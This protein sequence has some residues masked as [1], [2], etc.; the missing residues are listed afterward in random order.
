M[1]VNDLKRLFFSAS[2]CKYKYNILGFVKNSCLSTLLK[3]VIQGT[4]T[5]KRRQLKIAHN[6]FKIISKFQ[7]FPV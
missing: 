7:A 6:H 5:T 1:L 2:L 4:N 3:V